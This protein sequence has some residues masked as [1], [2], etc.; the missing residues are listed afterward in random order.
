MSQ[1]Q[2]IISHYLPGLSTAGGTGKRVAAKVDRAS[3]RTQ[4]EAYSRQNLFWFSV[5]FAA[6]AIVF[7]LAIWFVLRLQDDPRQLTAVSAASGVSVMGAVT[8]LVSMWARKNKADMLAALV[9][10]LDEDALRAVCETL[11]KQL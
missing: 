10:N 4:L 9:P 1:L 5:C 7:G 2:K 6:V 3:M 8:L 11:L